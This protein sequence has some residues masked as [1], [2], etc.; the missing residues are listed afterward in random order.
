MD[1]TETLTT[2]TGF[3][4]RGAGSDAE[5]RAALWLVRQ[6][7]SPRREATIETFWCRPNW[8]LAHAWHV[9]LAIAGSLVAVG[10]PKIGG[11]M[12]LVALVSLVVDA[13]TGR[14]LGRRLTP[15]RASQNVVSR[16]IGRSPASTAPPVTLVLTANY[17]AG[18]AGVAGRPWLRRPAARLRALAGGLAPGWLGWLAV[19]FVWLLVTAVLRA[20]G[21][22]GAGVGVAQ[23]LPTAA[24]VLG[25][26]LLLELATADVGPAA[27][28]N[29]SGVALAVALAR[30]LDAAPPRRLSVE[31]V[32]QGAGDGGMIGLGRH[33]R[34]RRKELTARTAIVL[35]IAP[36][37]AGDPA[38][39]TGDGPLL[40]LR[41]LRRLTGIAD[42]ATGRGTEVGAVPH[43]G[44]GTSA[45]FP[46]R[47]AGLPAITIGSL[48]ATGLA[49]RSHQREDLPGAVERVA[50]D[51]VL[52]VA[53]TLI[54]A[55]DADL[56]R[57][58]APAAATPVA[59]A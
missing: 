19:G 16:P 8:A 13:L 10:S 22:T 35:G 53:L 28:D 52:T 12:I 41:F 25:L 49:P 59:R 54:D 58:A 47:L 31:L 39:W 29:G 1:A 50:V 17:D 20:G 2:L 5:R 27:N 46:G 32:L 26:A 4:G 14:S 24:L 45:A 11:A 23:L 43:R 38:F 48:D 51:R 15:E 56:R 37:G 30:V 21:A 9:V 7:R 57:A 6:I 18:R 55:I 44:R 42:R 33:L 34:V 40:P 3:H 36:C